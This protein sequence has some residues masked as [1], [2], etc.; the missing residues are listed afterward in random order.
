M[1]A[2]GLVLAFALALQAKTIPPPPDPL[3]AVT[4]SIARAD[5]ALAAD[6]RQIA[7]S[8]YRDALYAGWMLL[9][10]FASADRRYAEA[11]AAFTEASSA[12]VDS[13]EALQ[14]LALIDLRLEDADAALPILTRLVATHPNDIALKRLLAQAL[15]VAKK[16]A[17][18]VQML[19]EAHSAAPAD[20][21]TSFA[22]AG[23]YLSVK[24]LDAA[25]P[26]FDAVASA[27]PVA[28]TYVLI[29]RAYRDAGLYDE[30][31]A[32]FRKAL[33]MNARVHHAHYYL[34]TVAVMEE[35]VVRVDEA[36][37]EFQRELTLTPN[38]QATTL[39]LGMA[40]VEAHRE[41]EALPLLETAASGNASWQTFQYLGR[42]R[43]ALDDPRAA[44]A[45][46]RRAIALSADVPSESQI[47]NLHYQYAQ[48]LRAS[49]DGSTASAEF[50][51]A[52]KFA[53]DRAQSRH[54]TL[55]R[56]L[57]GAG[58]APGTTT[59]TLTLDAGDIASLAAP[60]RAAVRARAA[61]ALAGVYL[62][63]GILQVQEKHYARA[64][65]LMQSGAALDPA[66]P[67]LQYSLGVAAFNAEQ[68]TV[69]AAA[70]EH[71]L[72]TDPSNADAR[73]ML[74]VASLNA[75]A[76][77]RAADL[78]ERDPDLQRDPS[79]QYAYG[80]ALIHSG[81]AAEAER[82]FSS[83]LAAHR[84]NP[85]LTVLL[86]QADAEQGDYDGAIAT[87]QRAV[88]LKP[89]IAEANRTLGV[90]YMKQGKLP[91]AAEAL[92]AEL[93]SHP[94][95]PVARDTLATVLDLQGHQSEALD[96]LAR[97]LQAR[98]QD[99]DARYLMGKI[100]LARGS[101][102]EAAEH[103]AIAARLAPE[104][105]NVFFQL[106]QAY[107][108]SGRAADAQKAFEHYQALKD[109]RRGGDR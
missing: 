94:S 26:L 49:G 42:C 28:E 99:A 10:A 78:L 79:L 61:T 72:A 8:R 60:T 77:D 82:L 54:D 106:A 84:D 95:D 92:R 107:Q 23:G 9:G 21:E 6:E 43:L 90:I 85:Q 5:A 65:A 3:A 51:I 73:R 45:A 97:A 27:R 83:L 91:Q 59:P 33:A 67:R 58:D 48:A 104:D 37:R 108:K 53:A 36:I 14:A 102:A 100:L 105:A 16:P 89:D 17:E 50:A 52:S 55:Q 93:A 71:A 29:G 38:D 15:I 39:L 103:L 31:R 4:A 69:A 74:A 88:Q 46:F 19:E 101:A 44:T 25:H 76:F 86:G 35:G 63:L 80:V 68:F 20:L 1:T 75:R 64:T 81:K 109:K 24:K 34:G 2:S 47:G 70:L 18:A 87:L 7:E 98:P 22:L 96:E 57:A 30:A 66:V 12:I 41:R 56:Y 13:G 11:R 40:L 62:N 32:A